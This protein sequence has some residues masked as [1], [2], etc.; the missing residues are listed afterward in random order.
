VVD[1][2]PP[3]A[4]RPQDPADLHA[5]VGQAVLRFIAGVVLYNQVVAQRE[6][7]GGSDGQF[8]SLLQL[9][10]P[11]SPGRLAEITGLTTGTVTGVIDRLERAGYVRRERDLADRRKVLV[12]LVPEA[13]ARMARHYES[14]GA[15]MSGVL[16]RRGPDELRVIA[17]FLTDMLGAPDGLAGPGVTGSTDRE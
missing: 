4:G 7:L 8:L 3:P 16:E 2:P 14:Y 11:L 17:D 12:T 13:L 10:G 9:N 5:E 6:G 15:H 1:V